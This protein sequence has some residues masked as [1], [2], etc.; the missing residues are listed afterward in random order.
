MWRKKSRRKTYLIKKGFQSRL[1]TVILL[2]VIIVANITGGVVYAIVKIDS[3]RMFLEQTFN[4]SS[5]DDILLPA[6]VLAEIVSFIIV[7]IISLFV[8]HRM[9]G[10]VYRFERVT[11]GI[12]EGDLTIH[13][14]LREKDEFKDLAEA[15]NEM[16]Q[17][18]TDKVGELKNKGLK[19][20]EEFENLLPRA[21]LSDE[22]RKELKELISKFK[23]NIAFFKTS[24]EQDED[25]SKK[26]SIA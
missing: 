19:L 12:S 11:E 2:L 1:I 6:V 10:P 8:S 17:K 3:F 15:F 5:A 7:G 14:R 25:S 18:L 22:R 13:I 20:A 9:A 21:E 4:L 26:E 23:E 24:G 16:I